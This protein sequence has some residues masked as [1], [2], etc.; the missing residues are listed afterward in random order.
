MRR[1]I[2]VV[3]SLMMNPKKF[4]DTRFF[5]L[6]GS[7]IVR[8]DVSNFLLAILFRV[9]PPQS[10]RSVLIGYLRNW[11]ST[12]IFEQETDGL[13]LKPDVQVSRYP[14]ASLYRTRS[15]YI[16]WSSCNDFALT[17]FDLVITT[18][19]CCMQSGVGW[20]GMLVIIMSVIHHSC[21]SFQWFVFLGNSSREEQ[22]YHQVLLISLVLGDQ[23]FLASELLSTCKDLKD[24][25]VSEIDSYSLD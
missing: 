8:S 5:K 23:A 17:C 1:V 2:N 10:Y 6:T 14:W 7:H 25:V 11:K 16:L 13:S 24:P 4:G 19:R 21:F 3:P 9:R 12:A 20:L 22:N 15:T 18:W